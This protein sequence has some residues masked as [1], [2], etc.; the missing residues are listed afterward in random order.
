MKYKRRLVQILCKVH[1]FGQSEVLAVCDKELCG[2]T[3][4]GPLADF[5]VSKWF[6]GGEG[7]SEKELRARLREFENINIV[8]NKAVSIAL[9]EGVVSEENVIDLSGVKHVQIFKI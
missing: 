9:A 3:L 4:K 1:G 8:G 2:K 5:A 6:Y 7:L